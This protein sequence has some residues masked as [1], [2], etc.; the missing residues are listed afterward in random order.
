MADSNDAYVYK[1]DV[2]YQLLESLHCPTRSIEDF[3]FPDVN[4]VKIPFEPYSTFSERVQVHLAGAEYS[5]R[6]SPIGST[7]MGSSSPRGKKRKRD[8]E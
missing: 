2:P 1:A 7:A 3:D 4:Y 8:E 6:S 5:P